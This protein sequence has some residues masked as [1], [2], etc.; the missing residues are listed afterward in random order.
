VSGAKMKCVQSGR[1]SAVLELTGDDRVCPGVLQIS[2]AHAATASLGE[3]I[4]PI[5]LEAV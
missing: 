4:G 2:A 1:A 5:G 3:M